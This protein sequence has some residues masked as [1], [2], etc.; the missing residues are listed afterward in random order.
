[1]NAQEQIAQLTAQRDELRAALNTILKG[2]EEGV[3]V[4]DVTGDHSK[5]WGTKL[6]PFIVA[7]GKAQAALARS[8]P[9]EA[10]A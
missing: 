8:K 10:S 7:L 5:D 4:R 2:F 9:Q 6:L 3:F 1:M